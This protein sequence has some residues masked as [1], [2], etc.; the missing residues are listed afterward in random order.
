MTEPAFAV[1]T[2]PQ[3][4]NCSKNSPGTESLR[5]RSVR[6]SHAP[7]IYYRL[8]SRIESIR[9]VVAVVYGGAQTRYRDQNE[10]ASKDVQ[11]VETGNA[12]ARPE[13]APPTRAS[14]VPLIGTSSIIGLSDV[15]DN[16]LIW[17]QLI[18]ELLGTFLLTSIGVAACIAITESN[19]PHVTSIALAFGLLVGSI[20][21][22]IAHVS[23]GHINPAVTAG[24]F[25]SGDIKLIKA[26]FYVIV[27]ALGAV[28]GAA[29]IRLAVPEDRVLAFG[30]TLPGPGVTDAQAVLVEA[31][32]T[33]VLVL[34]VQG[35]CDGGR[36][37]LKGSGPLA[38]GL[39]ITACHAACIPFTGSSMNPARS[40]G[41]AVVMGNWT[42]HWVYWVGPLAGGAIAG[43]LYKYVLRIGKD[44]AGSYDL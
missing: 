10:M 23:G 30:M 18:A 20:V 40:F 38:I 33:F 34:V 19:A 32:I 43:L 21:Q 15:T 35:V 8:Y 31:L 9:S 16:K 37:D 44:E 42:S 3:L 5:V 25:I 27:Q 1:D 29:F 13:V 39:S 26:L 12:N 2:I 4:I 41:P 36:S 24:L 11:N 14:R 28:A 22:A 7:K 17:R 6:S